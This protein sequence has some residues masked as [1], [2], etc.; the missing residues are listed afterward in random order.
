MAYHSQSQNGV[1]CKNGPGAREHGRRPRRCTAHMKTLHPNSR[2]LALCL[3]LGTTSAGLL[4][5]PDAKA[6]P[7]AR[8]KAVAKANPAPGAP[9][10]LRLKRHAFADVSMGILAAYTV[11]LPPG[12]SA[13]GKVEWRPVGQVPFP[14]QIIE[15]TSPRQGRITLQPLSTFTYTESDLMGRQGVPAPQNIVQWLLEIAPKV[16]PNVRNVKLVRSSRDGKAEAWLKRMDT[17]TGGGQ[18]MQREIHSIVMEYD[19]RSVRRREEVQ[20]TYVRFAPYVSNGL[21]S[22]TW[23]LAAGLSISAPVSTFAAQKPALINV[24]RTLGPTPQWHTQSQAAIAEMSRQR[25][26]NNW[27]II[28]ARGRQI[29]QLSDA[30]Y[31]KY[32]RETRS[33]DAAQRA[34]INGI[35]ETDDFKDTNGN[36]VNLPMHY[37][38]VFSDGKGNYVLSNN[39]RDKPGSSWKSI[40]PMK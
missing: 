26:A 8:P 24:A 28:K 35:Y 32:K 5:T 20:I 9:S 38:H 25:A 22:Q 21:S 36:I 16:D 40:R 6:K 33:S 34:R 27:E 17:A 14:Q 12:W 31:E 4:K 37:N 18:G 10:T 1:G 23:S 13:S 15:V 2:S 19:E 3:L 30:Q 7:S 11:M 39:S 29:S